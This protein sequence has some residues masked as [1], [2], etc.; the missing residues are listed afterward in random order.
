MKWYDDGRFIMSAAVTERGV[1]VNL[2][3]EPIALRGAVLALHGPGIVVG[4][5]PEQ[6]E[7]MC[8][9]RTGAFDEYCGYAP[10]PVFC[11]CATDP[12]SCPRIR[13][14]V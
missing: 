1:G 6:F 3:S 4:E 13:G 10:G 8:G 11:R 5:S 9:K 7:S 14:V 12:Q 2:D